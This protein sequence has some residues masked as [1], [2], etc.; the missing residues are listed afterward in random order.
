MDLAAMQEA[1][2]GPRVWFVH[3]WLTGW[4]GGEKVLH[5]LVKMFP[6]SRIATLVHVPGTTHAD[7]DRRV[8]RIS[9]LQKLPG[10]KKGWRNYLPLF[11][12]AV[13]GLELDDHCDIVISVSHA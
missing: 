4:R 13:R 8:Q 6:R 2:G 9:F 3:D 1:G 12:R 10:V 7:L 11:P 5:E